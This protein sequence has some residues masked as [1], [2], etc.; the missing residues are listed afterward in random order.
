MICCSLVAAT[1][2]PGE[3]D[4]LAAFSAKANR[5][6]QS[7]GSASSKGSITQRC[8]IVNPESVYSV[9][10]STVAKKKHLCL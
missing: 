8:A 6:E 4:F 3:A 5:P 7:R 1:N 10:L 9:L 2:D